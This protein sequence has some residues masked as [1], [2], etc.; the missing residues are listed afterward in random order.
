V[1]AVD[2]RNKLDEPVFS[3]RVSKD[4]K[5]F[6]Y[7]HGKQVTILKNA[8]AQ[9]FISKITDLDDPQGEAQLAMAKATGNFKRGNER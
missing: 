4:G 6:I 5:V 2:K 9:K 1:D 3:Y 7:W 8:A